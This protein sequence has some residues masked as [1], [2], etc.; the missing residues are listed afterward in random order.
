MVWGDWDGDGDL[1]LAAGNNGP[2]RVYENTGAGLNAV[3]AWSSS[4]ADRT[5]GIA[6]GDYDNDGDLDLASANFAQPNRIHASS[7]GPIPFTSIWNSPQADYTHSI[8]WGDSDG[9]YQSM[10]I[11][12]Y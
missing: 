12:L 10:L 6:W 3:A 5:I 7:A 1:D 11:L 9:E 2:N 8:A 4:E